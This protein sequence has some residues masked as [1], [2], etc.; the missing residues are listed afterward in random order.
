MT[1][2]TQGHKQILIKEYDGILPYHEVF[3]I[4]SI[5]F[6]AQKIVDS[7]HRFEDLIYEKQNAE[8]AMFE[9]NSALLHAAGVSKFFWPSSKDKLCIKRGEKLRSAFTQEW[10]DALKDRK[11]RNRIEHFDEYLDKF[12]LKDP[13]GEIFDLVIENHKLFDPRT[14]KILRLVDPISESAIIL[15]ELFSFL[16]VYQAVVEINNEAI[17]K[18]E[19]GGRL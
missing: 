10:V 12:L 17:S 14:Q 18:D 9:F 13:M 16:S 7:F 15:N 8:L 5:R 6:S 11:L 1:P 4:R 2:K 19:S 3:Y